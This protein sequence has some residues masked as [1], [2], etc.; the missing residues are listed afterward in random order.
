MRRP[1]I[2]PSLSRGFPKRVVELLRKARESALLAVEVY[3]KPRAPFRTWAYVV[4]MQIAWTALLLAHFERAGPKP[5]FRKKGGRRF[6]RVE[7]QPKRWDL[8]RCVE[9]FWEGKATPVT[10]NLNFFIKLR[11][12][13]EHRDVPELDVHIFG[14]CQALLSNFERTMEQEFGGRW[15]IE[16][17]LAIPLQLSRV[18]TKEQNEALR[19]LLKP[20]AADLV[21]WIEAFRSALATEVFESMEYS[22]R[23]LMVP[24]V[25]NNPN[26]ETLAVEFV[27]Y[28]PGKNPDLDTAITFIKEK[29]IPIVNLGLLKPGA[30]VR[31]VN[32]KLGGIS[33][34]SQA[35]HTQCWRFFHVRPPSEDPHP[36]NCDLRYC[37]FDAAHRDYLYRDAWVELLAKELSNPAR[38]IEIQSFGKTGIAPIDSASDA[39]PK[40]A[41]A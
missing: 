9:R 33:K 29:T 20:K 34:V 8:S 36:E 30:V 40:R 22:Y 5:Y 18:R 23:V 10:E 17:S 38:V 3:N 1:P 28:E 4:L 27:P 31:A 14:E 25:K 13:I 6:E 12:R 11:D 21:E 26:R 15:C 7:G 19:T 2:R 41:M 39:L 37:Y 35:L 32:A 16:E 24:N